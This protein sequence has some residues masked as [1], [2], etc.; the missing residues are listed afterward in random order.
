[1]TTEIKALSG[2]RYHAIDG[3]GTITLARPEVSNAIDIPTALSLEQSARHAIADPDVRVIVINAEGPRFCA[4]GD[5]AAM[6]AAVDKPAAGRELAERLDAALL[7]LDAAEKPVIAAVRGAVAG[8]GL[9][10]ALACDL[11]VAATDAKFLAAYTSIGITPDC[12]VSWLLPR[13]V[14]QQRALELVLTRRKLTAEE[15]R[16]WGLVTAVVDDSDLDAE[17]GALA[18]QLAALSPFATGQARRLIRSSWDV[19]R[20]EAT[21]DEVRTVTE[22]VSRALG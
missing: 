12:G 20:K 9:G 11:V 10:V 13:A 16:S 8:A 15:A 21:L 14:G 4:G 2:I 19:T 18:T 1:M 22:A 3:I 7:A 5:V 6:A 17:V